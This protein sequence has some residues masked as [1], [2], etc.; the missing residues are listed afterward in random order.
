M[1]TLATSEKG[2]GA[3]VRRTVSSPV[4]VPEESLHA[5]SAKVATTRAAKRRMVLFIVDIS[6][7]GFMKFRGQGLP[8]SRAERD[9][10]GRLGYTNE[11]SQLMWKSFQDDWIN[12][13]RD[14]VIAVPSKEK[15]CG[16]LFSWRRFVALPGIGFR[17][18]VAWDSGRRACGSRPAGRRR[19]V[20]LSKFPPSVGRPV[21]LT[22]NRLRGG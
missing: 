13:K 17:A 8:V 5:A 22:G 14:S 12:K 1:S 10:F 21:G 18:A 19:L 16:D 7:T 6:C 15:L 2:N 20:A 4:P 11:R 3:S 9:L